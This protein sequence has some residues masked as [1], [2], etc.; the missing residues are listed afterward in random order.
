[1]DNPFATPDL[2]TRLHA[3]PKTRAYLQQPDYLQMLELLKRNPREL[4]R[5]TFTTSLKMSKL[6]AAIIHLSFTDFCSTS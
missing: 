1:M 2:F 6:S 3:N 5:Y 4:G